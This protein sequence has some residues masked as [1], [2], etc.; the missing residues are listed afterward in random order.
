MNEE[1]FQK[2]DKCHMP[3][4]MADKCVVEYID[5]RKLISSRRF[6]FFTILYYIDQKVK[7][8]KDL[9]FAIDLYIERTKWITGGTLIEEGYES[10]AGKE[11]WLKDLDGLISCFQTKSFDIEKKLIPVDKNYDPIDGAHR[12]CCAAYFGQKLKVARFVDKEIN[13]MDYRRMRHD[14]VPEFVLDYS[15][16]YSCSWFND[17]YVLFLWPKCTQK[18]K[19]IKKAVSLINDEVDVVYELAL[20]LSYKAIR[21]LMIQLYG[22]MDWIGS[23]DDD[24]QGVYKKADEVWDNGG[25]IKV[26]LVR[27]DSC[28]H[29]LD[30]KSKVR[31]LFQIGLSSVHST[32]N[33]RE[34]LI[35]ANSL[36]NHN[37]RLFLELASP[38]RYKS[39]YK[40]LESFKNSLLESGACLGD[41]IVDT[42]MIL[43]ICGIRDARDLDYY[44]L[45][46]KNKN[47]GFLSDKIEEHGKDQ[48][49]FYDTDIKDLILSPENHFVFNELKFVSLN[50]LLLFKKK[51]WEIN[52]EGK[53]KDDIRL[54]EATL[55]KGSNRWMYFRTQIS[56][57]FRKRKRK[58]QNAVLKCIKKVARTTGTYNCL[59]QLKSMLKK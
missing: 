58:I 35:A 8:V 45:D 29:I 40:L 38:T 4:S 54:I 32:D 44:T 15:A 17:L 47:I 6:D 18:N 42:S 13:P 10:K 52:H 26:F 21:N 7:G 36:F 12:V 14:F 34:T 51:R 1:T 48:V 25:N 24:F 49:L 39:A 3:F 43:A 50:K 20:K 22:H 5:A 30:L 46:R 37:S 56:V 57:S 28:A 53:D 31:D 9:S 41:Y 55:S 27:S 59:K 33:M 2:L 11:R 23:I 16:L 19:Y